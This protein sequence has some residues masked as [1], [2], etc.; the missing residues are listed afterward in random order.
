MIPIPVVYFVLTSFALFAIGVV[1]VVATRHF[2]L[3]ILSIEVA[4]VASTLLATIFFYT[5][6]SGN[7]MLLL[8]AIWTIAAT[9]AIALVSFYRYLGRYETSL[10]VTKLSKLRD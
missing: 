9:E 6:V 3:M 8:F 4:L 10:D 1:G 2:L 5:T 7:I